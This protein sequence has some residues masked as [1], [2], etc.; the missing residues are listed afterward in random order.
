[1]LNLINFTFMFHSFLFLEVNRVYFTFAKLGT[2]FKSPISEIA[3]VNAF[4]GCHIRVI[5]F[6]GVTFDF[7]IVR[8]PIFLIRYLSPCSD[9]YLYPFELGAV[10]PVLKSPNES[11]VDNINTSEVNWPPDQIPISYSAQT[12]TESFQLKSKIKFVRLTFIFIRQPNMFLLRCTWNIITGQVFLKIPCQ[13]TGLPL[14]KLSF[15]S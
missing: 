3:I 11:A 5:N 4:A 8:E 2:L 15:G 1:M 9:C 14:L 7:R 12:L 13:N 6:R 10:Y